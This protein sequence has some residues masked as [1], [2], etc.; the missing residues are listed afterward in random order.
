MISKSGI[1]GAVLGA[2]AVIGAQKMGLLGTKKKATAKRKPA[3][4]KATKKK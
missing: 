4:R 1:I 3:K 2:G